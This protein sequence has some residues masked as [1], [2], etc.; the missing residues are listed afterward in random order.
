MWLASAACRLAASITCPGNRGRCA[1]TKPE[2]VFGERL[3]PFRPRL[4]PYSVA[5]SLRFV[6]FI[7]VFAALRPHVVALHEAAAQISAVYV[8]PAYVTTL[9]QACKVGI[10]RRAVLLSP[11]NPKSES[12][13]ALAPRS[14]ARMHTPGQPFSG[15]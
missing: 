5:L 10:T 8:V 7:M 12:K 6:L 4:M 11:S 15:C 13:G 2:V 14:L 9:D 3:A 1:Q